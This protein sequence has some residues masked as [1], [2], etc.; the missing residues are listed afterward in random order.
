MNFSINM[1]H[2]RILG[3]NMSR[4]LWLSCIGLWACDS[5]D[6]LKVYNTDPTAVITSHSDGEEFLE[7]YEI[8]F[9]GQVQD[10]NHA[11]SSLTVQ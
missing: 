4:I 2:S 8:T 6:T 3:E 7:G 11:A 9:V 10:D 5:E 1:E